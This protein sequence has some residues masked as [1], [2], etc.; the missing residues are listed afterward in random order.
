MPP[1][2]DYVIYPHR[3]AETPAEVVV[4]GYTTGWHL[5]LPDEQESRLTLLWRAIVK[6]CRLTLWQ[7]L[8]DTPE[9]RTQFGL[10]ADNR[11][12]FRAP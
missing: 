7:L 5:D 8:A 1:F 10:A 9:R 6:D 4:L 3:V 2:P 12:G 11:L